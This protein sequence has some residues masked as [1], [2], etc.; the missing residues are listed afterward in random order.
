M[1]IHGLLVLPL[2]PLRKPFFLLEEIEEGCVP[3]RGFQL[4][5]QTFPAVFSEDIPDHKRVE[6]TGELRLR[7]GVCEGG[8]VMQHPPVIFRKEVLR[9]AEQEGEG[10]NAGEGLISIPLFSALSAADGLHAARIPHDRLRIG[11]LRLRAVLCQSVFAVHPPFIEA[12]HDIRVVELPLFI[13]ALQLR[14]EQASPRAHS[15]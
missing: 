7:G 4:L 1:G 6:L 15:L 5:L 9:T 2:F 14:K 3:H 8:G 11:R 12:V 13:E 10:K